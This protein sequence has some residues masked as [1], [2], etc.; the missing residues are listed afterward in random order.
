MVATCSELDRCIFIWKVEKKE[1]S[2]EKEDEQ[3]QEDFKAWYMYI[4]IYIYMLDTR[5]YVVTLQYLIF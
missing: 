5:L 2:F 3:E 1:S 4:Y